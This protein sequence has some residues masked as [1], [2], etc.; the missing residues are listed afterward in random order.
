MPADC[1]VGGR[2]GNGDLRSGKGSDE[3]LSLASTAPKSRCF[4]SRFG[5]GV[6]RMG[7]VTVEPE[8]EVGREG[9]RLD[10]R[11]DSACVWLRSGEPRGSGALVT[12]P[13]SLSARRGLFAPDADTV[14]ALVIFGWFV[15]SVRT[16]LSIGCGLR[17]C[18]TA[19]GP[20]ARARPG[21]A[22]LASTK[23]ARMVTGSVFSLIFSCLTVSPKP[24]TTC[25]TLLYTLRHFLK[26]S[27]WGFEARSWT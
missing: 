6:S 15:A 5:V 26:D 23:L 11:G 2:G 22:T 1:G 21:T 3:V 24:N 12:R 10:R 19:I 8:E 9:G 7:E 20:T 4:G 13:V 25:W 18:D 16:V 14:C 17:A 27:D